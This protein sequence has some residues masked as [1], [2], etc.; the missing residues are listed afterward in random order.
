MPCL[1]AKVAFL[2]LKI[3]VIY[4]YINLLIVIFIYYIFAYD[5]H[6]L[7]TL[8]FYFCFRLSIIFAWNDLHGIE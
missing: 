2:R 3:N 8:I 1:T 7:S 6:I 4:I 5:K